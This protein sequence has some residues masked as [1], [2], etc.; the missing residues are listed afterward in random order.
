MR[1]DH[2]A[3]LAAF[4]IIARERSFTRAAAQVGVSG[5]ALS[6]AMRAL[7]ERVGGKLLNRTT[8]SVSPT[9]AGRTLLA[10][11]EPALMDI[12]E[13]VENVGASLGKPS[14]TVRIST[15]RFAATALIAPKLAL[16]RRSFPEICVELVIDEGFVDIVADGFDAG[17]RMGDKVSNDMIAV[18]IGPDLH[19]VIVASPD[20]LERFGTPEQPDELRSHQIIGYR[21]IRARSIYRWELQ[22]RNKKLKLD[23]DPVFVTNDLDMTIRAALDGLGLAHLLDAQVE[24]HLR[25]GELV[26]VLQSWSAPFVGSYL[27][28]PS[29]RQLSP[30][31]RVII[32]TLRYSPGDPAAKARCEAADAAD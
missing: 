7:E 31:F 6:H 28:Y 26:H 4:A 15:H 25:S 2:L 19:G 5:S 27:Y 18:R 14:G 12:R 30:A 32:D 11:L 16:L 29:R 22:K 3:D 13:A 23:L 20:Y 10:Q 8:R 1:K 21:M 9:D 17:V 24:R